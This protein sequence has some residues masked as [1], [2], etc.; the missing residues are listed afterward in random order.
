[1]SQCTPSRTRKER[2][3]KKNLGS[4]FQAPEGGWIQLGLINTHEICGFWRSFF[5]PSAFTYLCKTGSI[6]T[7]KGV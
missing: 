2:T 1:M 6:T 7:S 3:K 5:I 4:G